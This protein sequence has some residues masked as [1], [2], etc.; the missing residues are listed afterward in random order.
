MILGAEI[1]MLVLGLIA[2]CSGKLTLSKNQVVYGTPARLLG[3]VAMAPFPL[4]FAVGFA[5]AVSQGIQGKAVNVKSMPWELI[6]IEGCIVVACLATVYG[7]GWSYAESSI[8]V[9]KPV[10]DEYDVNQPVRP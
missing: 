9:A 7:V 10:Q 6:L 8:P 2:L 3:L 4:S 5:I 1:G